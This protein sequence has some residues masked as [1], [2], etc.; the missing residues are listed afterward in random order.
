[1]EGVDRFIT[2]FVGFI[3]DLPT[4]QRR[5]GGRTETYPIQLEIDADSVLMKRINRQ[6]R[7][8]RQPWRRWLWP[9]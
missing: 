8:Q 9:W 5:A 7:Y 2:K 6:L 1:M 3:A 4:L